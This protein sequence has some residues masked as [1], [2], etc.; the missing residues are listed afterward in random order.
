[1]STMVCF[2][3]T[4]DFEVVKCALPQSLGLYKLEDPQ[5]QSPTIHSLIC[6]RGMPV[7]LNSRVMGVAHR[8]SPVSFYT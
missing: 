3:R 1:M 7:N 4:A 2:S 8:H 6:G 5:Y